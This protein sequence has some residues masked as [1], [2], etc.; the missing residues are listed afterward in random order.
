MQRILR[1][2]VKRHGNFHGNSAE[3]LGKKEKPVSCATWELL[4]ADGMR[5]IR[6]AGALPTRPAKKEKPVDPANLA[7]TLSLRP[8]VRRAPIGL[9]FHISVR[10]DRRTF[11]SFGSV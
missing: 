9:G 3:L 4:A 1:A 6:N 5:D 11:I 8:H 2:T 7:R 10:I